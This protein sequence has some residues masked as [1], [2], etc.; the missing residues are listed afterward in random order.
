MRVKCH[1]RFSTALLRAA[2]PLLCALSLPVSIHAGEY[3]PTPTRGK[4]SADSHAVVGAEKTVEGIK[5]INQQLTSYEKAFPELTFIWLRGQEDLARVQELPLLLG[6]GADDEDYEHGPAVRETLLE[7]EFSR[8][9][10]LIQQSS[11]SATLFRSGRNSSFKTQ[12]VCVLT[13][14]DRVF[15]SDRLAA[16]RFFLGTEQVPQDL[17]VSPVTTLR[18]TLNHEVFHCL[19][20]YLNGPIFPKTRSRAHAQFSQLQAEMRA[21]FY[22]AVMLRKNKGNGKFVHTLAKVRTLGLLYWDLAHFTRPALAAALSQPLESLKF[23]DF[24]AL[25]RMSHQVVHMLQPSYEHFEHWRA[26]VYWAA[27][28]NGSQAARDDPFAKDMKVININT[29]TLALVDE[30]LTN[31]TREIDATELFGKD[32]VSVDNTMI[33]VRR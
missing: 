12:H 6:E 7:A 22:A 3:C 30:Q 20:A 16:S 1:C 26:A 5:L 19:D 8:I 23:D 13:L 10:G 15:L 29:K 32:I 4:T 9:A 27:I 2:F 18:F 14:D 31:I 24:R 17:I 28:S 25:A 33:A 21:D 11:P